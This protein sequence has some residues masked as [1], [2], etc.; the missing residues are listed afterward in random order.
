MYKFIIAFNEKFVDPNF[1]NIFKTY[2]GNE[3]KYLFFLST[4]K[5]NFANRRCN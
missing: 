1:G 3:E 4:L 2:K 5:S